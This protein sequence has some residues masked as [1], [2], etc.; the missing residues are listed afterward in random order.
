MA[1]LAFFIVV[2]VMAV[3]S[4]S[5]FDYNLSG[6]QFPYLAAVLLAFMTASSG[7]LWANYKGEDFRGAEE[8]IYGSLFGVSVFGL[9]LSAILVLS[10]VSFG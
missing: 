7:L 9:M 4:G 2:S 10:L 3:G 8:T 6:V 1:C 5:T